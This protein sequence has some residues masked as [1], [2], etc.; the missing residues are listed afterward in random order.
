MNKKD[1]TGWQDVFSFSFIQGVK[2]KSFRVILIIFGLLILLGLPISTAIT[3]SKESK[4]ET[5]QVEEILIYDESN[6]GFDYSGLLTGERYQEVA[7][8]TSPEED[9]DTLLKDMEESDKCNIVLL[10]IEYDA[11][12]ASFSLQMVKA[13]KTDV[14]KDDF[15]ALA[16]DL[17]DGFE[18]VRKTALEVTKEQADFINQS[19]ANKVVKAT[20]TEDGKMDLEDKDKEE[21]ISLEEYFILLGGIMI[22]MMLVNL[23]GGQI[24]NSIV[25]EKSTRVVEYLM[26]NVKPMALIVGKI[27]A[28]LLQAVIQFIFMGVCYAVSSVVTQILFGTGQTA[29]LTQNA[30]QSALQSAY[31]LM[32]QVSPVNFVILIVVI[33][34]GI[35][36]FSILAGLAGASVSKLEELAEGMKIY[37]LCLIGGTYIGI[38]LCVA[39][40]IGVNSMVINGLCLVPIAAPFVIPANIL[41]GKI[42]TLVALISTLLLLAITVLLF[43]FTAKVYESMIFYN[44]KVLKL[45]DILAIAKNRRGNGKGEK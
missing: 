14:S 28:S 25:T 35:A 40:I 8:V 41:L 32:G 11:E 23:S 39:E 19:V 24:A 16:S 9:F 3:N 15:S 21:G 29:E 45:K 37:Q 36:F 27:L 33:I 43:S 5:C 42:S 26:I 4:L 10:K 34:T 18:E 38:G 44:G 12:S 7:I 30:S 20:I 22:V 1:Y 31:A 17:S 13:A 2:D 6:L